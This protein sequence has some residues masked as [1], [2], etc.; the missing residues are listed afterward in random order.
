MSKADSSPVVGWFDILHVAT[1]PMCQYKVGKP[2]L[3]LYYPFCET[4]MA[5]LPHSIS[6]HLNRATTS[7]W[8][9]RWFSLAFRM[10]RTTDRKR[11]RKITA[12]WWKTAIA[13]APAHFTADTAPTGDAQHLKKGK[14]YEQ[15]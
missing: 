10:L 5:V 7:K 13:T 2:T 4:C 8:F 9:V 3:G 12:G 1:C 6:S 11:A 15:I 14:Q